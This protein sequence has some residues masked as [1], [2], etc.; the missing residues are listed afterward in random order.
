MS[1]MKQ[2][3]TDEK[4]ETDCDVQKSFSTL[5]AIRF[6]MPDGTDEPS[7]SSFKSQMHSEQNGWHKQTAPSDKNLVTLS[8]GICSQPTRMQKSEKNSPEKFR[9]Q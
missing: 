3:Y 9:N 7:K 6:W 5:K 2:T 8:F 1:E 4:W